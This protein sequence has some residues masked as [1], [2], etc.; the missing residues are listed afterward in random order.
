MKT[1]KYFRCVNRLGICLPFLV[2]LAHTALAC[3]FIEIKLLLLLLWTFFNF[4]SLKFYII[5]VCCHIK[6]EKKWNLFK[7]RLIP[8]FNQHFLYVCVFRDLKQSKKKWLHTTIRERKFYL[9]NRFFIQQ[10]AYK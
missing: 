5:F 8:T 3:G 6:E 2:D 7:I 1:N 9:Y 10:F 4:I